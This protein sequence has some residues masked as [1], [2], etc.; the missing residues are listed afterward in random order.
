MEYILGIGNRIHE[1]YK[2][3]PQV[4]I[5]I[6]GIL[7][8]E[9]T[10]SNTEQSV[11][12]YSFTREW[13]GVRLFSD[14][15]GMKQEIKRTYNVPKSMKLFYLDSEKLKPGTLQIKVDNADSNYTNGFMTKSTTVQIYP[16]FLIPVSMLNTDTLEKL[17]NRIEDGAV[18]FDKA[19]KQMNYSVSSFRNFIEDESP[20]WEWPVI[21]R[22]LVNGKA[23]TSF[24]FM[25]G[26]FTLEFDIYKKHGLFAIKNKDDE[27]KGYPLL[28]QN[29]MAILNTLAGKLK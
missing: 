5:F 18:L 3:E 2:N 8:E 22:Y 25:G 17:C 4:S 9:F 29:A 27:A 14:T 19:D 13:K 23:Q 1:F 6:N 12:E 21:T 11:V 7:Q 28:N 26:S 10:I 20:V 24:D 16:I 15:L